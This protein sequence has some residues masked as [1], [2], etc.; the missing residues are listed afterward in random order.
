VGFR[1]TACS[2][3]KQLAPDTGRIKSPQKKN[4]PLPLFYLV[5]LG[6][7]APGSPKRQENT[8][9]GAHAPQTDPPPPLACLARTARPQTRGGGFETY[10]GVTSEDGATKQKAEFHLHLVPRFT[11]AGGWCWWLWP[12]GGCPG[13]GGMSGRC[14]HGPVPIG[15]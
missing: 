14:W 6:A 11:A 9:S 15:S 2:S 12:V 1:F 4:R 7:C 10:V 5:F 13:C 3:D 8:F